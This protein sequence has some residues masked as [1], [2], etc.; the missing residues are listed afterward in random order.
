MS[1]YSIPDNVE[2][3]LDT[4]AD[5]EEKKV[6]NGVGYVCTVCNLFQYVPHERDIQDCYMRHGRSHNIKHGVDD[7]KSAA[8]KNGEVKK[9]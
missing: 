4:L 9:L 8:V 5:H 7:Y 1:Y 3:D 2:I 6:K